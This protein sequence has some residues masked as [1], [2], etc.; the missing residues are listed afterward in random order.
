MF[1]P[2]ANCAHIRSAGTYRFE[3][4]YVADIA[5][6]MIIVAS[7]FSISQ[8][9]WHPPTFPQRASVAAQVNTAS[10]F[11]DHFRSTYAEDD[12]ELQRMSWADLFEEDADLKAWWSPVDDLVQSAEL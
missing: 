4:Q 7:M 8:L 1:K 6:S 10:G 5:F 2:D 11:S 12:A 3:K 9:L